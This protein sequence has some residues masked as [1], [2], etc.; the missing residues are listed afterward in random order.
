MNSGE[1]I[2]V[3][4]KFILRPG[5]AFRCLY[6]F[7]P[8]QPEK[9]RFFFVLN[10]KPIADATLV[11]ATPTTQIERRREARG[12]AGLAALVS[13]SPREYLVVDQESVIDCNSLLE[14]SR[15]ALRD[16]IRRSE[17]TYLDPLPTDILERIRAGVRVAKVPATNV[18]R[19]V[20]GD[21]DKA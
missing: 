20:L 8:D 4:E 7:E 11:L 14:W 19:L 16:R 18:K 15:E 12:K 2:D 21:T 6:K 5:G 3:F 9:N 17:L 13:L 10:Q 1:L